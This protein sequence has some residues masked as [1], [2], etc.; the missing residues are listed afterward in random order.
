[1]ARAGDD[2]A[3]W[4]A[5]G[6]STGLDHEASTPQGA[7][8]VRDRLANKFDVTES[9]I[10]ELRDKQL[11]YGEIDHS[12]TLAGR[13]PGG[14]TDDNVAHVLDMRQQQHMGWGEIAHQMDSTMGGAQ[15]TPPPT[16]AP[17]DG[18]A[19]PPSVSRPGKSDTSTQTSA[20]AHGHGANGFSGGSSN[21]G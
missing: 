20:S 11:G 9:R 6:D 14:I 4:D 19:Q 18:A 17:T 8:Q 13:M 15:H 5:P 10:T 16:P 2:V 21:P 12:L 3:T 7:Q 1:M